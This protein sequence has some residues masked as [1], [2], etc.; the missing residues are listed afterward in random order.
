MYV[1]ILSRPQ[2][3]IEGNQRTAALV[4]SYVVLRA[5]QPPFVLSARNAPD[6]FDPSTVI[7][8]TDRARWPGA[9]RRPG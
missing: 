4:M 3:F 1:R 7:R 2:L 9:D 6:Y 8:D 5:G